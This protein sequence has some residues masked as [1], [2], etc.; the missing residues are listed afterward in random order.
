MNKKAF[1]CRLRQARL[2]QNYTADMLAEACEMNVVFLRQI[3]CGLKLPSLQNLIKLCNSLQVSPAYLLKDNLTIIENR[4]IE[5][6]IEQL[7]T[8]SPKQ[9]D[10]IVPTIKVMIENFE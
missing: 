9:L 10:V 7:R 5:A 2:E 1:G 6:I 4:P 3:E 8:L